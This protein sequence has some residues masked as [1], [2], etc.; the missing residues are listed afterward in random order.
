MTDLKSCLRDPIP[1]IFEAAQHP[2]Q[3]VSAHLRSDEATAAALI[4]QADLSLIRD[5]T[6][7]LWGKDGPWSRPLFQDVDLPSLPQAERAVKR[8]PSMTEKRA[9]IKRD[10][11][12][13]RFCG[14]P[15]IR[16]ETRKRMR[17]AYPSVISWGNTN[18]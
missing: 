5:W 1:E 15:L 8:M 2:N 13:C 6:N 14:I 9:L 16:Q 12:T 11:Y 4:R 18:G 7:S 3:A 10:G 17:V